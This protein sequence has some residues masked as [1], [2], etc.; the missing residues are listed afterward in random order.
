MTEPSAA[1][2]TFVIERRLAG[3]P[4]HAFSFW[5]RPDMKRRWTSCHPTW[6]TMDYS[7]DFRAG[8]GE[9]SLLR[10][11]EGTLHG[12]H[13]HY[14]DIVET[15]RI[16]YAYEM[17]AGETRISASL[18]TVLFE[19][20]AAATRMVFTEQVVFLDGGS[21]RDRQEGTES[22]FDRLALEIER[23]LAVVQ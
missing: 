2:A 6:T 23:D 9:V 21:A 1:H 12:M 4:R 13:A 17:T 15:K 20:T 7:L 14:L 10:S 16:V 3:S 19:P 5:S 22:G 18:V 8:G 11:P